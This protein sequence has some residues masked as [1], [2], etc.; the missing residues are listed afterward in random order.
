MLP[1]SVLGQ[2]AMV[3]SLSTPSS[4]Q[5][6]Q[7]LLRAAEADPERADSCGLSTDSDLCIWATSPSLKGDLSS[8]LHGYQ[9]LQHYSFTY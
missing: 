6:T 7:S 5:I 1:T 4:P 3:G 9:S 2:A 8:N